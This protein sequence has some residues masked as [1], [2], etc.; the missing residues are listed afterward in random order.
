MAASVVWT[1]GWTTFLATVAG[2]V[3]G[4]AASTLG[5]YLLGKH[6]RRVAR[7][8]YL[9]D[10]VLPTLAL[11]SVG[12]YRVAAS[13]KEMKELSNEEAEL[14]GVVYR[15]RML[16]DRKG[17]ALAKKLRCS[18]GEWVLDRTDTHRAE[19]RTTLSDVT[20]HVESALA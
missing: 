14:V 15:S 18:Y 8:L 17:K 9:H 19:Y 6:E 2:A 12:A 11:M 3:V 13:L 10:E 4:G 5:A 7:L 1:D 16:L 20:N